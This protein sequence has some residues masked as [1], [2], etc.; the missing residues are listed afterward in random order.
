MLI[1][2]KRVDAIENTL[3]EADAFLLCFYEPK[4][5]FAVAQ[6]DGDFY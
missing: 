4:V 3:D 5:D 1:S 6:G 2:K